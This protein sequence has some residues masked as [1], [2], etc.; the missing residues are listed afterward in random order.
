MQT[1][2]HRM[3]SDVVRRKENSSV[4]YR[5]QAQ[6]RQDSVASF[7][8]A[9]FIICNHISSLGKKREISARAFVNAAI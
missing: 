9:I 8:R 2:H 6:S 1:L 7:V 4:M 5:R 3:V